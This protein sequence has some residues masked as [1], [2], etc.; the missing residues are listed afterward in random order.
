MNS[1]Y[2]FERSEWNWRLVNWNTLVSQKHRVQY[3]NC[4]I[5]TVQYHRLFKCDLQNTKLV[6][7]ISLFIISPSN[8]LFYVALIRNYA[9]IKLRN[10]SSQNRVFLSSKRSL[11]N[12][13]RVGNSREN[14][15]CA[16][17]FFFRNL[18]LLLTR[19][20][21]QQLRNGDGEKKKKKRIPVK[22]RADVAIFLRAL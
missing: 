4:D 19:G 9:T 3:H 18:R 15:A 5:V 21:A 13:N 1:R 20:P 16:Q 8:T 6:C 17:F 10:Y 11:Q 22:K 7:A 14:Y 2:K 12:F